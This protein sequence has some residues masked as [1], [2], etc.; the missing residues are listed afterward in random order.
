MK[1]M[2]AFKFGIRWRPLLKT[3][4]EMEDGMKVVSGHFLGDE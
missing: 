1:V 4:A 2:K 3:E